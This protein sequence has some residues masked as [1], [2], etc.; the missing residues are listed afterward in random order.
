MQEKAKEIAEKY[1]KNSKRRSGEDYIEHS[2]R[3]A[4]NVS[5]IT[6][7]PELISAAYLHDTIE[8]AKDNLQTIK[9]LKEEI[10][11]L[12]PKVLEYVE[13]LTHDKNIEDYEE[14]INRI[15]KNDKILLLKF[16]DIT[17]N[18]IDNP[19]EKQKEKYRKALTIL[20]V[21]ISERK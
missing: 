12:S 21:K 18:L 16:C 6:D 15:S 7:N 9:K 1:H 4:E 19:T 2:K 13:N 20:L 10:K 11:N 5:K 17:D 14:Y 3:V 8:E